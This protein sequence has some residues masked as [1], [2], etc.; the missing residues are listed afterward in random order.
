MFALSKLGKQKRAPFN[1]EGSA[2]ED[3]GKPDTFLAKARRLAGPVWLHSTPRISGEAAP[4]QSKF[5]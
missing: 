3:W 2:D 1:P 4:W 5:P